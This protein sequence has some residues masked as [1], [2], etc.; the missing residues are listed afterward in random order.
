MTRYLAI[1]VNGGDP[2][3]LIV[4]EPR[5]VPGSEERARAH[6]LATAHGNV[7]WLMEW[8]WDFIRWQSQVEAAIEAFGASFEDDTPEVRTMREIY[9]ARMEGF[10]KRFNGRNTE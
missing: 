9:D 10:R 6:Q 3:E 4:I 7:V 5:G 2:F 8:D 1:V